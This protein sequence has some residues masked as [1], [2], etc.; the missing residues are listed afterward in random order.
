MYSNCGYLNNSTIAFEDKN[1]PLTIA[2][3]GAYTLR[4]LSKFPTCRPNGRVDYQLLSVA[5][6]KMRF[7]FEPGVETIVSAGHMVLY[8]PLQR[9]DYVYLA[10]D[11]PEVFWVHFTGYDAKSLL[12]Q[13]GL[14]EKQHVFYTGTSPSYQRLFR[15]MIQEFQ[16]C[17]PH[18]ENALRLQFEELLISISRHIDIHLTDNTFTRKEIEDAIHYFNENYNQNINIEAYAATRHMSTSGFIRSFK[19]YCNMTPLNYILS[20]RIAHAKS[21]L[22]NT[23]YNISEIASMV[24]YDNP[25][26]FSRLFHKHEGLSPS[27]Y[28]KM[29]TLT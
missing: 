25:L 23:S 28:R 2:S 17:R 7:F 12:S 13:Y 15:L 18:F 16:L 4:T 10:E 9:Q 20:I 11:H 5:S 26:Y 6:G 3:C 21:L 22:E 8:H 24:G 27:E 29:I 1:S 19:R 14:S